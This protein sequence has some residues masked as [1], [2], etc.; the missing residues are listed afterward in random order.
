MPIWWDLALEFI[1]ITSTQASHFLLSQIQILADGDVAFGKKMGLTVA[2]GA[3]GGLRL[4]RFSMI[5]S[6]KR[7]YYIY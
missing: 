1:W 5:V 2:S 7:D 4:R 3:F 6:S